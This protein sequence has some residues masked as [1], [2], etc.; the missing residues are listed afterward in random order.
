MLNSHKA[1]TTLQRR[2]WIY[3]LAEAT[4][5][6]TRL[7]KYR[8]AFERRIVTRDRDSKKWVKVDKEEENRT[9]TETHTRTRRYQEFLGERLGKLHKE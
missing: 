8:V 3:F 4:S 2:K 9:Q 6:C 1:V 5:T 7:R